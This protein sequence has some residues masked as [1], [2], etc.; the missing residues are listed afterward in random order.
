M[1]TA[2]RTADN[3]KTGDRKM[4]ELV[5]AE[6]LVKAIERAKASNLYV[7]PTSLPRQYRV[8]NRDNGNQYT[9]DFF[10]RDGRRYGQCSCKAGM[11]NLAC[12]HLSAAAGY[13]V[14]RMTAQ[15]ETKRT[16]LMSQAS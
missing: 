16:A 13:H 3:L 6:Q 4:I 15:R 5:S 11:R 14:M 2:S 9:V 8:T 7:Q 12:K 1:I 10:V